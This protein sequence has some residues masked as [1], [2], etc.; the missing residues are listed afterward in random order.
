MWN[1][2]GDRLH[3]A[4][5]KSIV[6]HEAYLKSV[7][8]ENARRSRRALISPELLEARIPESWAADPGFDP[9]RVRKGRASIAHAVAQKLKNRSYAPR[10]PFGFEVPKPGG[11][12][13]LVST[14]QL[15][16]EEVSR[17]LFRSLMQKNAAKFS[18]RAYAYR[19]DRGPQD[20]VEYVRS[21]FSGEH[22]LYV[23][24]YDFSKF[25]DTVDQNFVVEM[26]DRAGIIRTPLEEYL[27]KS[28]LEA[29]LPVRGRITK[30]TAPEKRKVGLPQGT[31]VS[32]FLANLAASS[33]DSS[34]EKIGVGFARYADDTLI[35]SQ[36][37]SRIGAAAAVL[38]ES[39]DVIGSKINAEKS[40]GVRL[41]VR[42]DVKDA[43]I[44]TV[45]SVNY[46]GHSVGLSHLSMKE[47]TVRK[48]KARIEHLIFVN[49]LLEPSRTNQDP[50]QFTHLDRDYVTLIFQLRRYIY[51]PL[52]E[53]QVRRFQSGAAPRLNF[54]GVMSYFP[55]V[56]DAAGLRELDA[57]M[58]AR[59]WLALRKRR[60]LSLG[61]CAKVLPHGLSKEDLISFQATSSSGKGLD[62]RVPSFVRIAKVVRLV[63]ESHGLSVA[64]GGT[65]GYL[66][67]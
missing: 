26:L 54:E 13:R 44:S 20:A 9:Y 15:V 32:L 52:N 66:Y 7:H 49:L 3:A 67:D 40:P 19:S 1:N 59:L 33:L 43:E 47:S 21:E 16:D 22:R 4:C 55:L 35:W 23:A 39:S 12:V 17:S 45:R 8:D 25:F 29:P 6:K 42:E 58:A 31:S 2:L 41:L 18:A 46:L 61:L 51:G 10:T 30:L 50:S 37:Y 60:K 65:G 28:F 24:E 27:I 36:D 34:L 38:H 64:S 11:G 57:W 14:F 56:D 63:V 48:I 5:T 62:L 53:S